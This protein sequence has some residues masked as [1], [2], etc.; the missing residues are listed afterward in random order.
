LPTEPIRAAETPRPPDPSEPARPP[1]RDS[2]QAR[3]AEALS[4]SRQLYSAAARMTRNP[5]D[6]E[7]LVQETYARAFA[8]FHQFSDGTNLRAWLHRILTNTFISS[9][10]KKQRE[11]V[12][13]TAGVEDWHLVRSQAYLPGGLRSAEELALDRMPDSR[14]TTAFRELPDDFRTA[15][16]L[17]DIEGYGYRE[18]AS[19]MGCPVGTVMSRLHRGRRRLRELLTERL[20]VQPA[21]EGA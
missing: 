9:H 17:A 1:G 21:Q 6:A 13:A 15:V 20:A 19:I 10:R 7:D 16:Y 11:P 18:I 14:V 5:A 8:S 4:H 2:S 12:F 3:F